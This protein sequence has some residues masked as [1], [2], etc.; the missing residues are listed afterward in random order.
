MIEPMGR[1]RRD[2]KRRIIQAAALAKE[3]ALETLWPTRC[4]L[5]DVPGALICGPCRKTL[6]FIDANDACPRCGAPFGRSQCTEC[7]ST[8]LAAAGR[9]DLPVTAMA[10]VLLADEGTRRIVTVYKD[11]NERRLAAEMAQLMARF[12]PP[13][14]S[15]AHL[16][17]IPATKAALSKRGFDHAEL[18]A[19]ELANTTGMDG[20]ALLKRPK[21]ADQRRFD[22]R[23]R[24]R[25]MEG[26]FSVRPDVPVPAK[27]LVIDDVCTTG[28]T[29][30]AAADR[31]LEAGA[32][33]VYAL[34]FAK[35][36]A[37]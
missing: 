33:E 4:A 17:Y 28:A 1:P 14:W 7:N 5:C 36:L 23:G 31:L 20:S 37:S 10:S 15:G 13:E 27:V 2:V 34:T 29:V 6:A 9:D 3:A 22:R 21:S 16:T 8:M 11:G 35:V 19:R 18:L 12:I 24:Q 32:H 25:N 30:F 26:R